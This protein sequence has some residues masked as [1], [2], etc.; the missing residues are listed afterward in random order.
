MQNADNP[1]I[2]YEKPRTEE[3]RNKKMKKTAKIIFKSDKKKKSA[4]I[5]SDYCEGAEETVVLADITQLL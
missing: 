4:K 1:L 5:I 3:K 2:K